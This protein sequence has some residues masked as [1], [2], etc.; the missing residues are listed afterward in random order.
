MVHRLHPLINEEC[1]DISGKSFPGSNQTQAFH[2]CFDAADAASDNTMHD[3]QVDVSSVC[4]TRNALAGM[5]VAYP[6]G[7]AYRHRRLLA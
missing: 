1:K 7:P 4:C 3:T 5:T 6:I 2:C